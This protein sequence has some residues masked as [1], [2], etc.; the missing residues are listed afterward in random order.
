MSITLPENTWVIMDGV[1]EGCS[2]LTN[3]ILP[4]NLEYIG[5]YAFEGCNNLKLIVLPKESKI[6]KS[7]FPKGVKI[8]DDENAQIGPS[9]NKN[10]IILAACIFAVLAGI[11]TFIIIR[12]TRAKRKRSEK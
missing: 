2:N 10:I 12:K 8:T 1:F 7:I 11:L 6:D 5:D 3:I 4:A 9:I